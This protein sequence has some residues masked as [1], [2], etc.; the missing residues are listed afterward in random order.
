M[1]LA[2]LDAAELSAD[3]EETPAFR[4]T[5]LAAASSGGVELPD[6]EMLTEGSDLS[7]A[8]APREGQ[9]LVRLQLLG[10]AALEDY[11]EREARLKSENG[12]IDYRF[13]FSPSG[14]AMCE[15]SDSAE[16]REGMK[17]F[18]VFVKTETKSLPQG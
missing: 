4:I 17:D 16:I 13:R 11:A 6:T 14:G 7:V 5:L 2:D 9:L 3:I 15:L 18:T 12:A 8:I 10:F 1:A